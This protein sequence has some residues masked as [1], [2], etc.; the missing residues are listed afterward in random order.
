MAAVVISG[1]SRGLGAALFDAALFGMSPREAE[2]IDPQ[3]RVFLEAA[4]E[5][6]ERAGYDSETYA[7]VCFAFA[8][9]EAGARAR[10]LHLDGDRAAV[11]AQSVDIALEGLIAQATGA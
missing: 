9:R 5:G 7:T 10:M 3:H 11:R 8:L 1:V 2:G 6:L 4:W